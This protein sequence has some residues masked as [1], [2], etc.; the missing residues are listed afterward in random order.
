MLFRSVEKTALIAT[1]AYLQVPAQIGPVLGPPIGGFITTYFSWRWIFLVNVP[2]GLLGIVLVTLFFDNPKEETQ[3]PARLDRL[4]AHRR[5]AVLHHV[6]RRGDRPRPRRP[7]A[8]ARLA[9]VRFRARRVGAAA[10][11]ARSA[12]AARSLGVPHPD[13]SGEHFRRLAVSRRCRHA[14]LSA[15]AA[16]CRSCSDCPRS[17]RAPSRLPP[18]PARCR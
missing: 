8:G 9:G 10:F 6:R 5:L 4:R 1:M 7:G 14:G 18:P 13:I 17:P 16:S 11:A 15:A 12:S 2:L 3:A